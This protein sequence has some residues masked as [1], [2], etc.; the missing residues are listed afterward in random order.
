MMDAKRLGAAFRAG[1]AF[2]AGKR[3]KSNMVAQDSDRWI[4]VHPGGKGP[5]SDG[6]GNKKGTPVLIDGE[7]GRIKGGMGGKFHGMKISDV[8]NKRNLKDDDARQSRLKNR[9]KIIESIEQGRRELERERKSPVDKRQAEA[10]RQAV[11]NELTKIRATPE[12]QNKALSEWGKVGSALDY[13]QYFMQF[14][15]PA[16]AAFRLEHGTSAGQKLEEFV[17][18]A[19]A[20]GQEKNLKK[21]ADAIGVKANSPEQLCWIMNSVYGFEGAKNKVNEILRSNKGETPLQ[22]RIRE[23][24]EKEAASRAALEEMR[25]HDK[26]LDERLKMEERIKQREAAM[27]PEMRRKLREE[28]AANAREAEARLTTTTYER[29]KKNN[30][31]KFEAYWRGNHTN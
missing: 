27:T 22:R 1:M 13:P 18:V 4:T 9:E 23:R 26:D 16:G 6:K 30:A 3:H 5:K 19:T 2:V 11:V 7:T 31:K 25:K 12:S 15:A 28:E 10:K 14:V 17:E 29:A 8:G 24:K 21:I 20:G